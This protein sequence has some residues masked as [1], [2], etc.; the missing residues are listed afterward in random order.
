MLKTLTMLSFTS[1]LSIIVFTSCNREADRRAERD[2]NIGYWK[3][4]LTEFKSQK[5]H[6]HLISTSDESL[7][8]RA[9][10]S[11]FTGT[12][13][14]LDANQREV[15]LVFKNIL[16]SLDIVFESSLA[17][18]LQ[19][20]QMRTQ[21]TYTLTLPPSTKTTF[22]A[23]YPEPESFTFLAMGDIQNG[24]EDID[25][26]V[27]K[28]N[29]F[30][31]QVDFLLFLGD[32]TMRS[33]KDEF[34]KVKEAFDQIEI[35]IYSTPGNHDVSSFGLYQDLFGLANYSFIHKGVRF[36]SIDS[37]DWGLGEKTWNNLKS[38]LKQGSSGPHVLY[39]HIPPK[40]VNG[41]R[42]GHWR[43]RRE[44][45]S[46]LGH[47][48]KYN[49]DAMFFGHLHT[50]DQYQ[51]AGIPTVV[52]GGAGAF[53]EIFDGIGRHLVKVVVQPSQS[54]FLTTVVRID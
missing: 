20:S 50:L 2:Q 14:N 38:W 54:Q 28:V 52:S 32:A 12:L 43:S 29:E 34:E 8:L 51:L 41:V 21:K 30:R 48:A 40:D 18:T 5:G 19:E 7:T 22:T 26:V 45:H 24:I 11:Q 27:S 46:F 16:P 33:G 15:E 47:A 36:T 3:G 13:Q 42:G 6:L 9:G 17:V 4:T 1:L 53:E 23:N 35:P 10:T 49:V 44:A 39:S 25:G 31:Q 37:G